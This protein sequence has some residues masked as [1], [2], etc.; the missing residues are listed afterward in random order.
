MKEHR[1][2]NKEREKEEVPPLNVGIG[3]HHPPD[4]NRLTQS[5]KVE[6]VR[7]ERDKGEKRN[8]RRVGVPVDQ[9]AR[10][11]DVKDGVEA[12]NPIFRKAAEAELVGNGVKDHVARKL[13]DLAVFRP[14]RH[15]VVENLVKGNVKLLPDHKVI[16]F[17]VGSDRLMTESAEERQA[18]R[19]DRAVENP[20]KRRAVL[21]N[22]KDDR[23]HQ[24]G[25]DQRDHDPRIGPENAVV[26]L[27]P[28]AEENPLK[29]R[30]S[31]SVV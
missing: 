20:Q 3:E 5:R 24:A 19:G 27:A 11:P 16:P 1:D 30:L 18:D 31:I 15:V 10:H 29:H 22:L 23:V 25:G 26:E 17:R 14:A 2:Q 4:R 8:D 6:D 13:F 12:E 9:P 7:S 21:A 28:G